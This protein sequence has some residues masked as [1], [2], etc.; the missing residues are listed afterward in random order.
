[1]ADEQGVL[2]MKDDDAIAEEGSVNSTRGANI[3][4]YF[5]LLSFQWR[6]NPYPGPMLFSTIVEEKKNLPRDAAGGGVTVPLRKGTSAIPRHTSRKQEINSIHAMFN[7]VEEKENDYHAYVF[8]SWISNMV[9]WHEGSGSKT[10]DAQYGEVVH[11]CQSIT[12][13]PCSLPL[14]FLLSFL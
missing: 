9:N 3:K 11:R 4:Q 1:M 14:F 2:R 7:H 12:G 10:H 8:W 5:S 6:P 13:F